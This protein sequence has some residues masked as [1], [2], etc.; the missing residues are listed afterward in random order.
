[1]MEG[2]C[3]FLFD[4]TQM[5]RRQHSMNAL[6]GLICQGKTCLAFSS[7]VVDCEGIT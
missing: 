7:N 5:F 2:D 3:T 4:N 1:M 6:V